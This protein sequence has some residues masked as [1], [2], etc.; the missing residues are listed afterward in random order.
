MS[1]PSPA[2]H[3]LPADEALLLRAACAPTAEAAGAWH[4]WRG[5]HAPAQAPPWAARLLPWVFHRRGELAVAAADLPVLQALHHLLRLRNRSLLDRAGELL[6]TLAARGIEAIFVKGMPM[7]CTVYP[8]PGLCF[9]ADVD[10]MLRR[11]QVVQAVELLLAAGWRWIEPP[12]QRKGRLLLEVWTADPWYHHHALVS[13]DGLCC[14]LHWDLLRYP[15]LP[16]DEEPAWRARR[17]FLLL[18]RSAWMPAAEDLLLQTLSRGF[19]WEKFSRSLRWIVD[20]QLLIR[21]GLIDWERFLA[22][23]RRR[24]CGLLVLRAAEHVEVVLPGLF[25]AWVLERLAESSAGWRERA[26]Y[27]FLTRDSR[28]ASRSETAYGHWLRAERALRFYTSRRGLRGFLQCT[29]QALPRQLLALFKGGGL[30]WRPGDRHG[31]PPR[32]LVVEAPYLDAIEESRKS[33]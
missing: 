29:L 17:G 33:R 6:D 1:T 10:L 25:P 15:T 2:S 23:A 16:V 13:P 31:I 19:T 3:E 20:V 8:D 21:Q 27:R 11:D 26:V 14:D 30:M 28:G 12:P 9:L 5:D 18:G 32:N 7:L 24:G 4:R 22:E